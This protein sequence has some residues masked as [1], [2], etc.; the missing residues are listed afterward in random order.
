VSGRPSPLGAL[1]LTLGSAEGVAAV[2]SIRARARCTGPRGPYSTLIESA[3]GS[4]LRFSQ[5][6]PDGRSFVA[7]VVGPH[8]WT[9]DQESGEREALPD[10]ARAGVRSHEFQMLPLT[11]EERFVNPVEVGTEVFDDARCATYSATDELGLPCRL[12]IDPVSSLLR[13][14]RVANY[15]S[16]GDQV[17][18]RLADWRPVAGV[19]MP[20]R[21]TATDGQGDWVFDFEKIESNAVD[22]AL[23]VTG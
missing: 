21:A 1:H 14:L 8:A 7:L 20:W 23:F 15:Y 12:Y 5:H 22:D 13:G 9:I 16:P 3:R 11:I 17:V 6:W 4:R 18:I 19:L 10:D 2:R